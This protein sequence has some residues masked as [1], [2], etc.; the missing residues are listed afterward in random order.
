MPAMIVDGHAKFGMDLVAFY[1]Q[2]DLVL[3]MARRGILI[4]PTS[5]IANDAEPALAF[6]NPLPDGSVRWIT[7]CPDCRENGKTS[8]EY[9]WLATPLTFCIRCGNEAIGSR[10]RR[11]LVPPAR[12]EIER[13]LLTRPDPMTRT[14]HPGETLADLQAQ[15]AALG[16]GG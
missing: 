9:V 16:I 3:R 2:P 13:L 11:V 10:W 1:R 7:A 6:V 5:D 14:W 15:N 12:A 4:P 8:S